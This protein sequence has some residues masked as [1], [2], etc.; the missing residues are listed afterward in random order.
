MGTLTAQQLTRV[1]VVSVLG[2]LIFFV[3]GYFN[4]FLDEMTV[5]SAILM[6]FFVLSL[7]FY[8]VRKGSRN[9]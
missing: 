7:F 5:A 3:I 4:H 1:A 8:R 9:K 2:L 6:E